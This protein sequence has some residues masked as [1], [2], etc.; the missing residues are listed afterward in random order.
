MI[1]RNFVP[2]GAVKNQLKDLNAVLEV[3]AAV[4]ASS[5]AH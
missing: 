1:D 4:R 3:F 2:G 5:A